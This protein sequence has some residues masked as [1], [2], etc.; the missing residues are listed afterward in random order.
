M[1]VLKRGAVRADGMVLIRRKKGVEIWGS[2]EQFDA[3][4]LAHQKYMERRRAEYRKIPKEKKWNIGD[5]NPQNGL[6]FIRTSGNL[7]YIWGTKDRLEKYREQR[8]LLR[9]KYVDKLKQK[10]L[11][12]KESY[13]IKRKRGDIDP[14]L[15]KVFWKYDFTSGKEIWLDREKYLKTLEKEKKSRKR[16]RLK[17]ELESC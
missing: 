12:T 9:L 4:K 8:K 7:N 10:K 2:K 17:E 16:L 11:E 6:Y 14:I 13:G 5:Y 15:N 1:E 3:L